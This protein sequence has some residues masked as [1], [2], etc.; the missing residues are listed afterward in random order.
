MTFP[1][2]R[3]SPRVAPIIATCAALTPDHHAAAQVPQEWRDL[4]IYQ[5]VTDRFDDGDPSNNDAEGVYLPYSGWGVNGGDF[6]GIRRRLP[7]IAGLGANAI[8]ISPVPLNAYGKYHGYHAIDFHTISAQMGGIDDLRA[9]VDDAHEAGIFVVLDVVTNHLGDLSTSL[10]PGWPQ[11]QNPSEYVLQWSRQD[12]LPA[13]PFDRLDWLHNN[14]E[15]GNYAD[16]EQILGE[17]SGLDDLRTE[18]GEVRSALVE[19]HAWLIDDTGADGFRIDTVK[20]VDME[21]W[22]TWPAAIRERA[23]L[24][25]KQNFLLFGEVFDGSDSKCGS[26]TGTRS[27]GPYALDSVLAYPMYYTCQ[28]VFVW[29]QP[30]SRIS[31]R[32]NALSSYDPDARERLV[33]FLDNHDQPRFLS[34]DRADGDTSRL[35]TALAFLLTARGI[36]AIYYGTE[37]GFDGRSDPANREDMFDGRYESG[38][39]DGDNFDPASDLYRWIRRL[40]KIRGMRRALRIGDTFVLEQSG[41][42]R[43]VF[44][45]RRTF[46]AEEV[47]VVLNTAATS[48][49]TGALATGWGSGWPVSDLLRAGAVI[50]TT[51]GAGSLRVQVPANGARVLVSTEDVSSMAPWLAAVAPD[52]DDR[53]ID[54]W[55]PLEWVFDR[56]MDRASV[57]A[58]ITISPAVEGVFEWPAPNCVLLRPAQALSRGWDYRCEIDA[59]ARASDDLALGFAVTTE[60][61]A[62][63]RSFDPANDVLL[64]PGFSAEHVVLGGFDAPT[65]VVAGGPWGEDKIYVADSGRIEAF[66][67]TGASLGTIAQSP[68]LAHVSALA[69]DS[70]AVFG[71]GLLAAVGDGLARVDSVGDVTLVSGWNEPPAGDLPLAV[72]GEDVVSARPEDN[73]LWRLSPGGK[74]ALASGVAAVRGVA[75][76]GGDFPGDWLVTDAAMTD[77]YDALDGR[78]RLAAVDAEGRVTT[79]AGAE[80]SGE[81]DGASAL[82]RDA[83]GEFGG[84]ALVADVV[85]ERVLRIT[86]AGDVEELAW[87]FG[88]LA[89]AGCLAQEPGGELLVLDAGSTR[90]W[91]ARPRRADPPRLVRIRSG[92]AGALK[93]SAPA[94]AAGLRLDPIAPNP[95]N[96]RAR[97]RFHL[98]TGGQVRLT[99]YALD[100]KRIRTLH[101]GSLPA[102]DHAFSWDGRDNASKPLPSGVYAVEIRSGRE[103]V[104]AR[105]LLLK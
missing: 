36:P 54:P 23:A 74:L 72:A 44:A 105:V 22:Q 37:Q 7:Y 25:G 76:S 42:G 48:R 68:L 90:R 24:A 71:G 6:E 45:F 38:P 11:F 58:A 50:D 65:A 43:G 81:L 70:A 82:L 77:W 5:I 21:F 20:H 94:P 55:A 61:K 8:W 35:R 14:G 67:G 92:G 12:V 101:E 17:L 84:D 3:L 85:G 91:T 1:M 83:N 4:V 10:S 34:S 56:A 104:T 13:P 15:I 39:S 95:M 89:S 93:P 87:N 33:T 99:I 100:G 63:E 98:A 102:G 60:F 88:N 96:P 27:G 16:P 18:E 51:D 86:A 2:S 62:A 9:L 19:A 103:R 73:T 79:V 75:A 49:T 66:D 40:A 78:G 59:S 31:S 47:L 69:W 41:G 32:W 64:A 46:G 53:G 57:E 80:A 29:G 28:D 52:H 97:V 30:T 26:Y